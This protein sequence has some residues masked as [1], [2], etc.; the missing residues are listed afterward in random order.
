MPTKSHKSET[1][2]GGA[3]RVYS[4][5]SNHVFE[6]DLAARGNTLY[7]VILEAK[8]S[9]TYNGLFLNLEKV[10][11]RPQEIQAFR[12]ELNRTENLFAQPSR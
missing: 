8:C 12:A 10:L 1:V 4:S 5:K 2:T 9:D 3:P 6:D 11:I 7:K